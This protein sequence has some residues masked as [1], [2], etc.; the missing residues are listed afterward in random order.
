[1]PTT[2][3]IL[4]ALALLVPVTGNATIIRERPYR[5]SF[6]AA[7]AR[8]EQQFVVC[9]NC[10]DSNLTLLPVIPQLAVRLSVP[11]H[12]P[13]L[14][15]QLEV[16]KPSKVEETG[17]Q[18]QRSGTV[19]FE[20]GSAHLSLHEKSRL[21]DLLKD[22]PDNDTLD[23]TGY[24]CTIG[25]EAYNEQLALS[26]AKEVAAFLTKEGLTVGGVTGRGK[27]CPVSTDKR[28]NRRVEI[29]GHERGRNEDKK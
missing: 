8:E 27:C 28:L 1:M 26:R 4:T 2:Q 29:R 13:A 22:F 6:E 7:V 19:H 23:V 12:L 17:K 11:E 3:L 10:P 20:F 9:S 16:V 14:P 18:T 5:F 25:S 21:S 24:T 15:M